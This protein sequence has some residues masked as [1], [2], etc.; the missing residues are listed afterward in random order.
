MAKEL[1]SLPIIKG[2]EVPKYIELCQVKGATK[3]IGVNFGINGN[4][5]PQPSAFSI[6]IKQIELIF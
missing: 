3:V 4:G 5:T 6:I 2:L 1:S